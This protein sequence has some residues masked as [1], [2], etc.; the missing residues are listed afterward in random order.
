VGVTTA[1]LLAGAGVFG[2]RQMAPEGTAVATTLSTLFSTSWGLLGGK[3][4]IIGGAAAL[5]STQIAQLAGWPRLLADTFRICIP[6]WNKTFRWKTQFRIFLIFFF[7]SNMIIIFSLGYKPVFL[8]KMGAILDGLLLTPLQ[9][10]WIAVGL[11]VVMP[12]LYM[13]ET[14]KIIRP[15]WLY[16]VGLLVAFLVFG[17]FCIFQIPFIL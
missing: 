17:Y 15:H 9:A 3:L 5:L 1:F 6:A 7:L 12:K 16:A 8:V 4:F 10:L 11:Y 14:W 13:E 2:G